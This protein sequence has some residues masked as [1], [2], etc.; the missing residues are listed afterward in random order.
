LARVTFTA[1]FVTDL[2]RQTM[3]LEAGEEW[4]RLDHLAEDIGALR[5]RLSRF[6]ELGREL[7]RERERSLR[8]IAVGRL[9][10]FVWYLCD[11]RGEG[12]VEVQ[13]IFHTR[14]LTPTP[15]LL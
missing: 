14:Q 13:R 4:S 8:R 10:Y 5:D 6:P 11:L 15:R 7:T 3:D 1:T 12:L 9:P 2:S